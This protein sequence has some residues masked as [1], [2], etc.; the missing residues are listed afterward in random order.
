MEVKIIHTV[1]NEWKVYPSETE[2]FYLDSF[3]IFFDMKFFL[4]QNFYKVKKSEC[5]VANCK[6][7]KFI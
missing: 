5:Q 2:D 3:N 4:K 1:D 6:N 7:C